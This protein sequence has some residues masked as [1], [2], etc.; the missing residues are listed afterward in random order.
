MKYSLQIFQSHFI[1]F[2]ISFEEMS[3]KILLNLTRFAI[4]LNPFKDQIN[5]HKRRYYTETENNT[6]P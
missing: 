1:R 6:L 5:T 3:K 2:A 4:R